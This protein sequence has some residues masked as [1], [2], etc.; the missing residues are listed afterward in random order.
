MSEMEIFYGTFESIGKVE[1]VKLPEDVDDVM[2]LE[3]K[4]GCKYLVVRGEVYRAKKSDIPM[5]T[6]GFSVVLPGTEQ[7]QLLLYWYNGGGGFH[8]VAES[9]IE[10]WLDK[11]QNP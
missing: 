11:Q 3:E 7:N 5:D 1:D 6:Y 4:D 8:E 9:A 10:N 2:D